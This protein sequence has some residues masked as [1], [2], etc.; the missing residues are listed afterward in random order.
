MSP[1][2]PAGPHRMDNVSATVTV[3]APAERVFALLAD[4]A[5]HAA[6]DGTG[7]VRQP[8]DREQL[9]GVGQV[10]RMGMH[11]DNHPTGDY[12][13]A[14]EVVVLDPPRA[15]AWQP[16]E[17]LADGTLRPGG[18]VWRYDLAP[19]GG[20]GTEVT[21]TY[22][23]SAVPAPVREHIAFPP[24]PPDHLTNSVQHLAELAGRAV[25]PSRVVG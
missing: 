14:N 18:W 15:I 16:V 13:V 12:Q 10:F 9:T 23:W 17:E 8:V 22:D 21:L 6:I 24:F 1:A 5:A 3:D 11:H 2:D 25:G 7:W 4:P 19:A 20:G